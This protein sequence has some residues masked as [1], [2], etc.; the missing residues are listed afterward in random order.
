MLFDKTQT[1]T[2]GWTRP[3][4]PGILFTQAREGIWCERTKLIL[5]A[6]FLNVDS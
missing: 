1:G 3:Y 5:S 2:G 6:R 4:C